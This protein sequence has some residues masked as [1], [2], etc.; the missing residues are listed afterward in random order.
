MLRLFPVAVATLLIIA[1]GWVHGLWT[2]R[3]DASNQGA[4][5]KE[6]L[7][8]VAL[9]LGDWEMTPLPDLTEEDLS[10]G[11]IEGFVDR[12]AVN[13]KTGESLTWLIVSGRP[14]K[15]AVH[16]PDVCF[17]GA[18]YD[19]H[20]E[21]TRESISI[22]E[23]KPPVDCWVGQFRKSGA[24][25]APLLEIYWSW[26]S[27]GIWEA[28]TNPRWHFAGKPNL[29]K[30]Y[31][32]RSIVGQKVEGEPNSVRDFLAVLMPELDRCLFSTPVQ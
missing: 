26:S 9:R 27:D 32:I 10:I 28:S 18:G 1:G 12:K 8:N 29:Y 14:G 23:S 31:V 7:E 25:P 13:K 3:W 17:R 20:G 21:P 4:V 6:K 15:I 16:T 5:F 2:Y 19:L 30:L 24:T 11:G 22:G